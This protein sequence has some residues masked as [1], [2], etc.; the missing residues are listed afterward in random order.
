MSRYHRRSALTSA[1]LGCA[2]FIVGFYFLYSYFNEFTPYTSGRHRPAPLVIQC[3]TWPNGTGE[4]DN[5]K[6]TRIL[7]AMRHTFQGY[8]TKA[9]THDDIKPVTGG[10]RRSRNGWGVFVVDSSSTLALMGLRS[11]LSRAMQFIADGIDF[12]NPVGLVDPFETTI[13]YLG[14]IL[15]L[16][17]LI[18][19]GVVPKR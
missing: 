19:A 15:S 7:H 9:W 2:L 14:G 3:Q 16:V 13:R 18:D 5:E 1:K 8:L 6:R 11:E 4:V 12:N 17:D 10:T